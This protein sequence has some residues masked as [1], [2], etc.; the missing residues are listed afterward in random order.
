[1]IDFIVFPHIL[2]DALQDAESIIKMLHPTPGVMITGDPD[3]L[4][5]YALEHALRLSAVLK[6]VDPHTLVVPGASIDAFYRLRY[7][8]FLLRNERREQHHPA[9]LGSTLKQLSRDFDRLAAEVAATYPVTAPPVGRLSRGLTSLA[10]RLL[11]AADRERF[12]EDFLAEIWE[13]AEAGSKRAQARHALRVLVRA[14]L[15][16][17]ELRTPAE[18]IRSW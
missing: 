7:T 1:M 8:A 12:R 13:I 11:P 16:R 9:S 4:P 10:V 3:R 17:R 15:L 2:E 5:E 14:P 18:R 6:R